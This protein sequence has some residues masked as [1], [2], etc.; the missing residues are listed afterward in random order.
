MFDERRYLGTFAVFSLVLLRLVIGWHF[1]REGTQKLEYDRHD[2]QLRLVF[3]AEG[4][5]NQA[6]GPL[7]RWYHAQSAAGHGWQQLLARPQR[8]AP[9]TPEEAAAA[10][11]WAEDYQRRRD[12]A[13]ERGEPAPV[14]FPPTAP[15]HDWAVRIADDWRAARDEFKKIPGITE[16]Q[17]RQADAALQK[18]LQLLADY[19]AGEAQAMADYRHELWRL[20]NWRASSEAGDVPFV[21]ERIATKAAETAGTPAAWTREVDA[22][23]IAYH[24]ELRH[25]LTGEQREQPQTAAAFEEALTGPV[26]D[27]LEIVNLVVTVL[28]I[29]VG[30][31]LMLGLFTWLAAVAGALFLVG[32]IVSQPPWL[33]DSLPTM[34]NIIEFAALL[35]L[36]GTRA[37]R[38]LGLDYFA[39]A[40]AS[41]YWN[42]HSAV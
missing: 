34:A 41:R 40:L 26:Q 25:I 4:F 39:Y 20:Q 28:I 2:G 35:V 17:E 11:K 21:D 31:C 10:A 30:V 15:Y 29:A 9:S 16:E 37:G 23:Q 27:R 12:Q 22:L 6:K 5:M 18:H 3:T 8:H 24:D 14:E 32:V 38:W 42:R 33:Q 13:K 19:L 7:A 36:A 1:F